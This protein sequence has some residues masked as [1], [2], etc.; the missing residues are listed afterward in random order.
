MLQAKLGFNSL[1]FGFEQ[2]FLVLRRPFPFV[3]D[4]ARG[5]RRNSGL[6][7][8]SPRFCPFVENFLPLPLHF[9]AIPSPIPERQNLK[10]ERRLQVDAPVG[11]RLGKRLACESIR[12]TEK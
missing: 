1:E 10:T 12:K 9:I 5:A 7:R 4:D 8:N 3:G 2:L 11:R 6:P